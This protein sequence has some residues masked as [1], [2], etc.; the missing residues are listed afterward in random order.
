MGNFKIGDKVV[1]KKEVL[2]KIK[3]NESAES[4]VGVT[5]DKNYYDYLMRNSNF[6]ELGYFEIQGFG[7]PTTQNLYIG[8]LYLGED[9]FEHYQEECLYRYKEGDILTIGNYK[10]SI[11]K[12]SVG[13][14]LEMPPRHCEI[15]SRLKELFGTN[16]FI[17]TARKCNCIDSC[18]Y[19]PYVFPYFE[20][21]EDLVTF[22]N[23]LN[24]LLI[25]S[26]KESDS[27][28]IKNDQNNEIRFQKPKVSSKR[29]VVPAGSTI[30]GRKDK[31][32]ISIGHLSY[33]VCNC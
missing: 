14:Y 8:G 28:T 7:S 9:L 33:Q 20:S 32:A 21:I 23:E 29:G 17:S 6:K 27:I 16:V 5:L 24:K 30:S 1:F 19:S 18:I 11:S 2:D 10:G 22:V 3:K 25:D 12:N 13:Y 31:I 4:L 15:C 26:N